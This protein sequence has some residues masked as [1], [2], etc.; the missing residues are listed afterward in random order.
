MSSS[1]QDHKPK[2]ETTE[3]E[4]YLHRIRI[5][6]KMCGAAPVRLLECPHCG[7]TASK[8]TQSEAFTWGVILQCEHCTSGS[9]TWTVCR[10]CPKA[11]THMQT[12]KQLSAHSRNN[13]TPK[14]CSAVQQPVGDE[15]EK[16]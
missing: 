6:Q 2:P 1:V 8:C 12:K 11:R 5:L 16:N 9:T 15:Q 4:A 7:K 13:H 10:L 14:T 3:E